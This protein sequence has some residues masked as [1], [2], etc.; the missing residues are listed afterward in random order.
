MGDLDIRDVMVGK[1]GKPIFCPTLFNC[2]GMIRETQSFQ[3]IWCPPF[4][5]KLAAEDR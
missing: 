5:F 3:P 1:V 4:I 2:L